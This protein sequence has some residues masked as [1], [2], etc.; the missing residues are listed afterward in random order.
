[1]RLLISDVDGTI[2]RSDLLGH[3]LPAMGVDWS[4]AGITELFCNIVGNGYQARARCWPLGPQP[5]P[6]LR[7]RRPA[8]RR[9]LHRA[10]QLHS[11]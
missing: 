6:L 7:P 2:T 9:L 4:H 11:S 5:R 3:V 1:M 10:P 8:G